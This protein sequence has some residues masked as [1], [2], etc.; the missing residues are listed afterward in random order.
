MLPAAASWVRA[1]RSALA[2]GLVVSS[3]AFAALHGSI[4]PWLVGYYVVFGVPAG[5][6]AI[7][8]GGVEASVALHVATKVLLLAGG[9]LMAGGGPL[10]PAAPPA[11]LT[12]RC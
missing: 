7:I 4:D 6:T 1:I 12:R 9:A 8:S 2:L 10:A 11:P 3:L 5:L